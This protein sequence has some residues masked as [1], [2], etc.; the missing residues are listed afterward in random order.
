MN[1]KSIIDRLFDALPSL[2]FT[3]KDTPFEP[4]GPKN[5]VHY[6]TGTQDP[7]QDKPG[8]RTDFLLRNNLLTIHRISPDSATTSDDWAALVIQAQKRAQTMIVQAENPDQKRQ[9]RFFNERARTYESK[10]QI[11][12]R[13][14]LALVMFNLG[15]RGLRFDPVEGAVLSDGPTFGA[16]I[17]CAP[18]S[19]LELARQQHT[20]HFYFATFAERLRQADEE[21][22]YPVELAKERGRMRWH[23]HQARLADTAYRFLTLEPEPVHRQIALVVAGEEYATRPSLPRDYY[24]D[25]AFQ[26]AVIDAEDGDFD[27]TLVLSPRY[28]VVTLD[29][30]ISRDYPWSDLIHHYGSPWRWTVQTLHRLWQICLGH[31]TP[32]LDEESQPKWQGPPWEIW[33]H[34]Q[35]YYKFT[36]F[37]LS[38]AARRLSEQLEEQA[39]IE[40]RPGYLT[41]ETGISWSTWD[42][43]DEF[44][45]SID[46]PEFDDDLRDELQEALTEATEQAAFFSD[47]F[48][49]PPPPGLDLE[50]YKL[51]SEEALE[52]IMVLRSREC[53]V[54]QVIQ[55][56]MVIQDLFE[57]EAVTFNLLI[58]API[59]LRAVLDIIHALIHQGDQEI[60]EIANQVL[61][62]QLG[63][64]VYDSTLPLAEGRLCPLITFAESLSTLSTLL[65][66]DDRDRLSV[67]QRTFWAGE[68]R[69]RAHSSGDRNDA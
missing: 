4:V 39:D 9:L 66:D 58:D 18:D 29:Q 67:W 55:E 52:P 42:E 61:P 63:T 51:D 34:P 56:G 10:Q 26:Q 60:Y 62:P 40:L 48:F 36:F 19:A 33:H 27:M 50:P 15:K 59:R 8:S 14:W 3:V 38:E 16:P 22:D 5:L 43:M 54:E 37:G 69:H 28:Q 21:G 47:I 31:R 17:G 57:G 24:R 6:L 23:I 7:W 1:I 64:V 12:Q 30:T 11:Q 35:S 53:D 2:R 44:L 20:E 32:T 46:L 13:V 65:N 45:D 25:G 49:M 68:L 41:D